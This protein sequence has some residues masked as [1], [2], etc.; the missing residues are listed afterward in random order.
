LLAGYFEY[1]VFFPEIKNAIRYL[2]IKGDVM[3]KAYISHKPLDQTKDWIEGTEA[4]SYA[5]CRELVEK[6]FDEGK[7]TYQDKIFITVVK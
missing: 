6:Q 1:K 2:S 4:K 3:Y 7:I 5:E